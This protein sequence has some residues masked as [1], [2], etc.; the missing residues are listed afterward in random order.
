MMKIQY[1]SK[2]MRHPVEISQM[3]I[4]DVC[5]ATPNSKVLN[6]LNTGKILLAYL[7]VVYSEFCGFPFCKLCLVKTFPFP[8]NNPD[9]KNRG[10]I[11]KICDRKF[12][13]RVMVKASK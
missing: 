2:N 4:M 7:H 9:F 12:Y 1:F 11:C 10:D 8:M 13:I 3:G 6:L 5:V